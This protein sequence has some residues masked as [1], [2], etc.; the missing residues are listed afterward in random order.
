MAFPS[1][2]L[3]HVVVLS[4]NNDWNGQHVLICAASS[5]LRP[6][7]GLP[8]VI[9]IVDARLLLFPNTGMKFE[10][11]RTSKMVQRENTRRVENF[12]VA[13]RCCEMRNCTMHW[14]HVQA[15]RYESCRPSFTRRATS[16]SFEFY[17]NM[18]HTDIIVRV[19]SHH[20]H[21]NEF[22]SELQV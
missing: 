5:W 10:L 19:L 20:C 9:L 15:L 6:S 14:D 22:S 17:H 18:G 11:R 7:D 8:V 1:G 16:N 4:L 13:L 3:L 21:Y 12:I 2:V